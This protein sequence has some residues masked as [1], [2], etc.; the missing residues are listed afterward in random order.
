[1]IDRKELANELILRESVRGAIKVILNK[2]KLEIFKNRSNETELRAIINNVIKEAQAAVADVAK[3][4]STGINTLEDL[5]KNTNVLSVLQTGYKSLTTRDEDDP[6]EGQTRQRLSYQNHIL[7]AVVRSLAPEDSRKKAGEDVEITEEVDIT[8]SDDPTDDPDFIDVE[9]KEA[10]EVDPKEEFGLDGE[11]K[12]GRNKAFSDFQDIE[13]NILTAFDDLDNAED[14]TM[15][16]E[17]LIKN[18]ALYFD[19]WEVELADNVDEPAAAAD[20]VADEETAS[21][22]LGDLD[23]EPEP[24]TDVPAFELQEIAALLDL[25]DI[26]KNIL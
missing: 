23:D 18:L 20:A 4:D 6:S 7:N 2:R 3:H 1:M 11:D 8:I 19:K 5:L 10:E 16:E 22:D 13:K 26:I 14:I 12:T 15:F 9:D 21:D 17:Y 24:E 25:D